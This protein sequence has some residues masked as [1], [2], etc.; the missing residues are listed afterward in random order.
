MFSAKSPS[1]SH[2][3]VSSQAQSQVASRVM[4]S[5]SSAIVVMLQPSVTPQTRCC[6]PR[7]FLSPF[8][9]FCR[10]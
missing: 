3:I 2:E 8:L 10:R 4:L 9:A 6:S 7:P 5:K 1:T